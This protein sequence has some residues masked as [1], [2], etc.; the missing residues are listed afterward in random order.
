MPEYIIKKDG[1]EVAR[2]ENIDVATKDEIPNAVFKW[3]LGHQ[4]HSVY[5]AC[6]WGGYT[7]E[8]KGGD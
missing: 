2:V 3:L 4:G 8:K 5:Y 1:V 6:K 7:Y